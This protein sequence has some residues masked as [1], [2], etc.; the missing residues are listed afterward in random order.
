MGNVHATGVVRTDLGGCGV[1]GDV[2]R[3]VGDCLSRPFKSQP[4]QDGKNNEHTESKHKL[5][6][7]IVVFSRLC[8]RVFFL[9]AGGGMTFP[10]S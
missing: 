2:G 3:R 6:G 8:F 1:C 4:G 9:R 5:N 10:K 7:L